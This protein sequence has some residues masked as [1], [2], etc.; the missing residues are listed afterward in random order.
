MKIRESCLQNGIF[1][2]K[3]GIS[4]T[5]QDFKLQNGS[6]GIQTGLSACNLPHSINP[7]PLALSVYVIC[8]KKNNILHEYLAVNFPEFRI[9]KNAW[10]SILLLFFMIAGH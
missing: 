2:Y 5:K 7:F 9:D 6:F 1:I 4:L 8:T 10:L 3:A